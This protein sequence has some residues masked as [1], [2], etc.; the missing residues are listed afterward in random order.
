MIIVA[1]FFMRPVHY[2]ILRKN[3]YIWSEN[4]PIERLKKTLTF[5]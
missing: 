2:I 3:E 5:C 4:S 1:A